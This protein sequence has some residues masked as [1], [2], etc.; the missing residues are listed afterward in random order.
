MGFMAARRADQPARC[1]R[2]RQGQRCPDARR[3]VTASSIVILIGFYAMGRRRRLRPRV[4]A[5]DTPD[6]KNVFL[7]VTTATS[8]AFF[9]M[10]GFEDSVN[11]AEE[12]HEPTQ[13][14]PQDDADGPWY[15]RPSSTCW[16][17]ICAVG[18][19]RSAQLDQPTRRPR[20]C[21]EVVSAGAPDFPIDKILPFISMFAVANS[22]LINM[23][24]ASRLLYGMARQGVLPKSLAKVH[25]QEPDAV[26]GDPVHHALSSGPDRYVTQRRATTPSRSWRTTALLLLGVFAVVNVACSS[27]EPSD[28]VE[29]VKHFRTRTGAARRCWPRAL[30]LPRTSAVGP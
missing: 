3:A 28:R 1:Q 24:M 13:D 18:S 20:R 9:A 27:C 6:D 5:F 21:V 7:A 29:S 8:M 22:A 4:V 14:L 15:H 10:V 12:C 2:E 17:S 30:P 26:G 23:M 19:C 11:M 25:C 16:S